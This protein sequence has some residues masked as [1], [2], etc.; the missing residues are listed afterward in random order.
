MVKFFYHAGLEINLTLFTDCL[1]KNWRPKETSKWC[2]QEYFTLQECSSC[3]FLMVWV[4]FIWNQPLSLFCFD[5]SF[6]LFNFKRDFCLFR[7]KKWG[8]GRGG[9]VAER[10]S[11]N[12]TKKEIVIN[13]QTR[14]ILKNSQSS[15]SSHVSTSCGSAELAQ[16]FPDW[17]TLSSP[18]LHT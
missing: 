8:G 10:T 11:T 12:L 2:S 13:F 17:V 14:K 3:K 15:K 5:V 4:W 7:K 1:S 9:L 18:I 6:I 16:L